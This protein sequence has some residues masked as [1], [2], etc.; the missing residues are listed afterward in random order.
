MLV[1]RGGDTRRYRK[2]MTY[3]RLSIRKVFLLVIFTF[4]ESFITPSLCAIFL[5][6]FLLFFLRARAR[7]ISINEVAPSKTFANKITKCNKTLWAPYMTRACD[8]SRAFEVVLPAAVRSAGRF[9]NST[10]NRPPRAQPRTSSRRRTRGLTLGPAIFDTRQ[11]I[12]L[13]D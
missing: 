2:I 7:D 1:I 8:V 10:S 13:S 11:P 12:R 3:F 4:Y 5:F 6:F 9:Q